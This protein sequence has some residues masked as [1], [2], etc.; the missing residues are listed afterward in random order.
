MFE[1]DIIP[2][3]DELFENAFG[4]PR[5]SHV[6]LDWSKLEDLSSEDSEAHDEIE[7]AMYEEWVKRVEKEYE[8]IADEGEEFFGQ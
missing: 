3:A 2:I 6:H 7:Q 4:K 8:E 1:A 5:G